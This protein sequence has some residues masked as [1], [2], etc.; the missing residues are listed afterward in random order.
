MLIWIPLLFLA[1]A[2]HKPVKQHHSKPQK[3]LRVIRHNQ[4]AQRAII[5]VLTDRPENE[6]D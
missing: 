1:C 5:E 3:H 6:N 4:D 2:T